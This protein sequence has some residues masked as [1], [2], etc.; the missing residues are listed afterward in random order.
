MTTE[1]SDFRL[2]QQ[3]RQFSGAT[4]I[5]ADLPGSYVH[6]SRRYVQPNL[7]QLFGVDDAAGFY[8]RSIVEYAQARPAGGRIR[9]V[10]IGCGEASVELD[11]CRRLLGQGIE[12]PLFIC[13]D[14]AGGAIDRARETCDRAGLSEYFDFRSV[15]LAELIR[16]EK[17]DVVIA[18]QVLHHIVNLEEIFDLIRV[19]IGDDGLFLTVDMIGRN[20]HMLWPEA[21]AILDRFWSLLPVEYRWNRMFDRLEN[22]YSNW[23]NSKEA[24][25]GI[26]A[27]DILSELTKRFAFNKFFA[28]GNLSVAL[29]GRHFGANFDPDKPSDL[30]RIEQIG[31]IDHDLIDMGYLKPV[32]MFAAMSSTSKGELQCYRHWTPEFCVRRAADHPAFEVR[33]TFDLGEPIEPIER[34]P[35]AACLADGW[36]SPEPGGV[37]TNAPRAVIA[38]P[39]TRVPSGSLVLHL[40]ALAHLSGDKRVQI[41]TV[42]VNRIEVARLRFDVVG[43]VKSSQLTVPASAA[44]PDGVVMVELEMSD[45][46][47]P[48]DLGDS[49]DARRLG[50]FVR[51][52]RVDGAAS[53]PAHGARSLRSL[54]GRLGAWLRR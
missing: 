47:S 39:M 8:A 53:Q 49:A 44:T 21:L 6:W 13:G 20:G 16:G 38:I 2:A 15:E 11:L 12:A 42:R 37:W 43:E 33:R 28:M 5:H 19:A 35:G 10:S 54:G 30:E 36:S 18:N 7:E 31:R 4:A 29:F 22:V 32:L 52:F 23:D 51:S 25:E 45:T 26:R 48:L 17:F 50:V 27:E 34:N 41:V 14:V 40:S 1:E 46:R 3:A 24:N 9:I